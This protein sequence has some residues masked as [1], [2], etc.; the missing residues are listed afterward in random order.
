MKKEHPIIFSSEMVRAIIEGRKTETRRVIRLQQ[1][2]GRMLNGDQR[3]WP[4][5][6]KDDKKIQ[7]PCPYGDIGSRLWVRET[8]ALMFKNGE[9]CI[10]DDDPHCPCEGC[11]VEYK[12]DTNNPYPGDWPEDEAKGNEDAPKWRPSI[13]MP[14]RASRIILE[15][16][17]IRVEKLQEITEDDA[18]AEG[19][20]AERG[21]GCAYYPAKVAFELL[22]NSIH[23]KISKWHD[24]P[25]VWVI[26]FRRINEQ[27]TK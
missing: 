13:Y 26:E 12:A 3:R 2:I 14:R 24:N 17:N 16:I 15:I 25:W 18:V 7:M 11:V 1:S 27:A 22:W 21:E 4:Y 10:Y 23:P 6:W 9:D 20:V 19:C 8:W 5:I